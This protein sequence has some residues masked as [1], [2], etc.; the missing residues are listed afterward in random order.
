[1]Y[2]TYL[3]QAGVRLVFQPS[4]KAATITV[5]E[6]KAKRKRKKSK[7]GGTQKQAVVV[8]VARPGSEGGEVVSKDGDALWVELKEEAARRDEAMRV[9]ENMSLVP[10]RSTLVEARHV[11]EEEVEEDEEEEFGHKHKIRVQYFWVKYG[12]HWRI[13][14]TRVLEGCHH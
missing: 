11:E 13:D 4:L 1:M 12:R 2:D 5:P 8:E 6:S 3:R 9:A 10:M 14:R 7:K